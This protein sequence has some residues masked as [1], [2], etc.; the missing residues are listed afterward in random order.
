MSLSAA[1]P[2]GPE[3][4]HHYKLD[5]QLDLTRRW[6]KVCTKS[7]LPFPPTNPFDPLHPVG[8]CSLDTWVISHMSFVFCGSCRHLAV[9]HAPIPFLL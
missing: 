9:A 3:I 6:T 5:G 8:Y 7:Y 4:V 2:D 1:L